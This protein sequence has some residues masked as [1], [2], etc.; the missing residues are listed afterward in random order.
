MIDFYSNAEAEVP[1]VSTEPAEEQNETSSIVKRRQSDKSD[2]YCWRCHKEA[3]EEVDATCVK[4]PRAYHRRCMGGA[5]P[6][7]CTDWICPE[8]VSVEQSNDPLKRSPAMAHV[9]S[10]QL[11][12]MLK[13]VIERMREQTGV[14]KFFNYLIF[15]NF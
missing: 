5:P 14:R 2:N 12:M 13:Y 10:D 9:T 15:K 3:V 11:I 6:L 8:C 4:C 7:S 1:A